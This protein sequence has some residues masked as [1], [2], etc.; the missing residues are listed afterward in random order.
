[1]R[2]LNIWAFN[3]SGAVA[4]KL[5]LSS[6][7]YATV[8]TISCQ[9]P[10]GPVYASVLQDYQRASVC[11]ISADHCSKQGTSTMPLEMTRIQVLFP[12][13]YRYNCTKQNRCW[14]QEPHTYKWELYYLLCQV[15]S[16]FF[17]GCYG[18]LQSMH[19]NARRWSWGTQAQKSPRGHCTRDRVSGCLH[20]GADGEKKTSLKKIVS[21]AA[22]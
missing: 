7:K 6:G 2:L 9:W 10:L 11:I 18:D 20:S 4:S 15:A 5:S 12:L 16:C 1:M 17:L 13:N 8:I 22:F 14:M 21:W 3:N 19:T